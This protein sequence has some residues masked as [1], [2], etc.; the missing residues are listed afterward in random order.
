MKSRFLTVSTSFLLLFFCLNSVFAQNASLSGKVSDGGENETLVG[1]NVSVL[2]ESKG[3]STDLDGA[4]NLELEAGTYRIK[5]SFLG[6]DSKIERVTLAEGENRELNI[7][8][9][10]SAEQ[11]DIVV[12]SG[13]KYER[14][15]SEETFSIEVLS[16]DMIES[17]N[18]VNLREGVDKLSGVTIYDNQA[19]IR[20]GSGFTYSVGSRVLSLVDGLPLLSVD[21]SEIRWSQMPLEIADQVEVVKSASSALYGASALNGVI[22]IRT[23]WAKAKP[24]T[25]ATIYYNG[26][27]KPRNK[28]LA[29]WTNSE[30]NPLRYGANF[31]HKQRF[32]R[33]DVVLGGNYNKSIGF[34]RNGD[35][36]FH[37]LSVKYRHRPAKV[38][39]LSYGISAFLMETNEFDYIFWHDSGDNKYIPF[40]SDL[41]NW[42]SEGTITTSNR[43]VAIV[44][45]FIKF[46]HGE[47]Y[48]TLRARMYRTRLRFSSKNLDTYLYIGEYQFQR[49]FKFGMDLTAGF[50]AQKTTMDDRDLGDHEA[51]NLAP[52]FQIGQKIGP[53]S[54]NIGARYEHFNLDSIYNAGRPVGSAGINYQ[55]AKNTFLRFSI[56]QGFRFPGV[57][58][59]FVDEQ[60]LDS[61][62]VGAY[63][64]HNLQP[65][66][67]FNSELGLKQSVRINDWLGFADLAF[68]WMEYW[69]MV[70]FEFGFQETGEVPGLG[71]AAKNITRARVA[72]IEASLVGSGKIG[73]IPVRVQGGYTYSYGADISTDSTLSKFGPFMRNMFSAFVLNGEDEAA[74]I[75]TYRMRHLLK[76]DIE[77]DVK[78][79]TFGNEFRVYGKV[80][81]ID[82]VFEVF[83]PGLPD[84][85]EAQPK[86]SFLWNFRAAYNFGKLGTLGVV[87]N[88]VLNADYSVRVA[89]QEAPLNYT[90]QYRVR[91]GGD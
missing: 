63:P 40:G 41:N 21:R 83:I 72:G 7:K 73:S 45:P 85:R 4:Y 52:Y 68:F 36:D 44:D 50:L 15:L 78:N 58:E 70:V 43:K 18:N 14:N 56:G 17:S 80:D 86:A 59:R 91:I 74:P 64:N 38:E 2:G 90:V 31:S 54:F 22:N 46:Y 23:A 34:I 55:A 13:S 5:F 53:V 89:R 82:Q 32:G 30:V 88:N 48:H 84:Y 69:D 35:S 76:L 77:F 24:E 37:R 19:N 66:Y 71:F 10:T 61:P 26:Y 51:Y 12:V 33:H 11:L 1:V 60:L 25:K 27:A 42:R 39:G 8:L 3:V 79:F 16:T 81:R 6:Y 75:L 67:G 29:W 65:E 62:P 57:A 49:S 9:E 20:G 28:K 87:I 47:N